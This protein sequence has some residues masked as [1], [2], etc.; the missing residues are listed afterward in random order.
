MEDVAWIHD[1]PRY[2]AHPLHVPS[3]G[4]ET[5]PHRRVDSRL[6][7][8]SAREGLCDWR[9]DAPATIFCVE[10]ARSGVH[11]RRVP[12][13][14]PCLQLELRVGIERSPDRVALYM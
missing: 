6:P 11:V 12:P 3:A 4:K 10:T 8:R 7:G 14:R 9:C 5:L 13:P 2:D 1:V